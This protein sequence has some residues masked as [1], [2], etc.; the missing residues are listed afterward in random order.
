MGLNTPGALDRITLSCGVQAP[1]WAVVAGASLANGIDPTG[2]LTDP[3]TWNAGTLG[4]AVQ[5]GDKLLAVTHCETGV[6][7]GWI[8]SAITDSLGNTWSKDLIQTYGSSEVAVWSTVTSAGTPS[9]ITLTIQNGPGGLDVGVA[10]TVQ[11]FR[12]LSPAAGASGID[13]SVIATHNVA[14]GTTADSGTSGVTTRANRLKVGL[15]S[16]NNHCVLTAG[17]VDATYTF[18]IKQDGGAVAYVQAIEYASSGPVG[19]TARAQV[20]MDSGSDY[21]MAAAVYL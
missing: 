4:A 14:S 1:R 3:Q 6:S 12:G 8:I 9:N 18:A 10:I 20:G 15:F 13:A 11:A 21:V 16:T 17:S 7:T 19:S 5:A 2:P